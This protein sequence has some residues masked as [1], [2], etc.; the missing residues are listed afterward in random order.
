MF[1]NMMLSNADRSVRRALERGDGD[2]ASDVTW[3]G[4]AC[5]SSFPVQ[6]LFHRKTP[7]PEEETLKEQFKADEERL[8]R[9]MKLD[10]NAFVEYHPI[11]GRA[12][13]ARN[14]KSFGWIRAIRDSPVRVQPEYKLIVG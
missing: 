14:V 2:F 5:R 9:P 3:L 12:T 1:Y 13:N 7:M 10:V 6:I 4:F 8:H 11:H